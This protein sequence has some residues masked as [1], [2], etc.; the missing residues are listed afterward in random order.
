[1]AQAE[2]L[3][4]A[5]R[6]A[7]EARRCRPPARHSHSGTAPAKPSALHRQT[8]ARP[9][10]RGLV[11][12]GDARVALRR[13]PGGHLLRAGAREHQAGPPLGVGGALHIEPGGVCHPKLGAAQLLVLKQ[14]LVGIDSW[15]LQRGCSRLAAA[16]GAR[17]GAAA[18]LQPG[19][20]LLHQLRH[21]GRILR[22]SHQHLAALP[23][24]A[25]HRRQ[26]RVARRH[27]AGAGVQPS[28]WLVGAGARAGSAAGPRGRCMRRGPRGGSPRACRQA[29]RPRGGVPRRTRGVGNAVVDGL[30]EVK[31]A[32]GQEGEGGGLGG[33]AGQ[34]AGGGRQRRRQRGSGCGG[35]GQQLQPAG[36]AARQQKSMPSAPQQAQ[37]QLC[38]TW[39]R[40]RLSAAPSPGRGK[41]EKVKVRGRYAP[42]SHTKADSPNW[43]I[44][45]ARLLA[46]VW[47]AGGGRRSR[48]G[49]GP[50]GA[51]RP[52]A[53]AGGGWR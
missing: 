51:P 47:G 12:G 11:D 50:R 39:H 6:L 49:V 16:A 31:A 48:Q 22:L 41:T 32:G 52:A 3:R 28:G 27:C 10:T 26:R 43:L 53:D 5:A 42:P 23:R 35:A 36:R 46:S 20:D 2:Q 37:R 25:V 8:P 40:K 9:P 7:G 30:V 15:Q 19:P 17:V 24:R 13:L 1:M 34:R 38:A 33:T 14:A 45:N 18:A 44:T 4:W 29:P 21:K